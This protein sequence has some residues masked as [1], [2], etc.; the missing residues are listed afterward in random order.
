MWA[1]P[2]VFFDP[3]VTPEGANF[4]ARLILAGGCD[5]SGCTGEGGGCVPGPLGNDLYVEIWPS[6]SAAKSTRGTAT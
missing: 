6:E 1:I 5:A 2:G 3:N 4:R